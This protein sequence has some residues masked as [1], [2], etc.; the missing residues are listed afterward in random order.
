M[1][2]EPLFDA[3]G[4][5]ARHRIRISGVLSTG[6]LA[7]LGWAGYQRLADTGQFDGNKWA[8]FKD[9]GTVGFLLGGLWATVLAAMIAT[10]ISLTLAV[11]LAVARLSAKPWL[12]RPAS[13]FVEFFRSM[14][15]L[16]LILF[17][18]VG[19]PSLGLQV[20][21]LVTLTTGMTFYYIAVFSEVIRSG[22]LALAR[23]QREAALALGLTGAQSM[24]VV[25]LP[26]ALYAM[27]PAILG[28]ILF[29]VQD[30]SLGYVIPYEEL[31]RR[32]QDIASFAPQ[33][34]LSSYVVVTAIYGVVSL[35]LMALTRTVERRTKR[36]PAR[37]ET[38][39]ETSTLETIHT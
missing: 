4:P 15:L 29:L 2:D 13:A 32:G 1:T 8:I 31:L 34:L 24:R 26:Q 38:T 6:L 7:V 3:P 33:T 17:L 5:K 37:V 9:P 14:P 22:L 27:S 20:S 10:V 28:Q 39:A 12:T 21:A 23:G 35:A 30:T 19:L 11:P 36:R 18:A 25:E 16:L